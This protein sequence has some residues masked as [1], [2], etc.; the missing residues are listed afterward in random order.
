MNSLNDFILVSDKTIFLYEK[1][2]LCICFKIRENES[3]Y[4]RRKGL[5]TME[6]DILDSPT[7]TKHMPPSSSQPILSP[8]SSTSQHVT[9]AHSQNVTPVPSQH[10]T[11]VPSKHVTPVHS[12]NV[13]PVPSRHVTPVQSPHAPPLPFQNMHPEDFLKPLEINE[14]ESVLPTPRYTRIIHY[15]LH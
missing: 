7:E 5:E 6:E 13:T 1:I 2:K 9:P 11:P 14:D 8:H 10:G 3:W 15:T 4:L 12:Q